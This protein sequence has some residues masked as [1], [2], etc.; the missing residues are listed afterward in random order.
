[1]LA[2][3]RRTL[4]FLLMTKLWICAALGAAGCGLISSDVT[5]FKLKTQEHMF[6]VDATMWM[7]NQTAANAYLGQS[8]ASAPMECAQWVQSACTTSCSGS[9]DMT[10]QTCDLDLAV[11][12]Y[13]MVDFNS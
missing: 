10:T 4:G 5:D 7:V 6:T 2:R 3:T 1:M 13:K 12:V 8:C 9:C 11:G